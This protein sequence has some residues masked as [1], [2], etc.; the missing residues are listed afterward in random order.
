MITRR[1]TAL[2][3]L[4]QA[5]DLV[6]NCTGLGSRYLS[7]V[8]DQSVVPIRGQ[9]IRVRA[10]WVRHA[11][12][13][14]SSYILPNRDCIILGGTK[15]VD[16]YSLSPDPETAERILREC[17]KVLPS[18]AKAVKVADCVGL[19]PYRP[20][21]RIE[22]DPSCAKIIHNYGHGG[23]GVTLCWGSALEVVRLAR[24]SLQKAALKSKL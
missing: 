1:I 16:N 5:Y 15:E 22:V 6:I 12:M 7:D 10:P 8:Q 19:R 14:G 3:Q 23:S 9:V 21:I 20:E 17:T 13:A 11:V 2:S 18:L 4:T 24:E